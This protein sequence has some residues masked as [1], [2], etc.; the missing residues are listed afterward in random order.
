MVESRVDMERLL[1]ASFRKIGGID[2]PITRRGYITSFVPTGPWI[3][4]QPSVGRETREVP[5][6]ID[7]KIANLEAVIKA[8]KKELSACRGQ[9]YGLRSDLKSI[10]SI[11][12][13]QLIDIGEEFE[14]TQPIS[15]VLE[16]SE[17]EVIASFPEVELFSTGNT[18]SEAILNLK[19]KLI[20]LFIDL[21]GTPQNEL[22]KLPLVWLR[23]LN[24]VIKPNGKH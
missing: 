12:Q 6:A 18:E 24:K 23:I 8:L 17:D 10:P 22:G 15:I 1:E 16:E 5:S 4:A 9:I 3:V 20:E 14:L 13:T 11:K 19:S 21:T 7:D 2:N